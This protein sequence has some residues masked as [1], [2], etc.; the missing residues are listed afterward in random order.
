MDSNGLSTAPLDISM[1]LCRQ[2]SRSVQHVFLNH[3]LQISAYAHLHIDNTS[4]TTNMSQAYS[5]WKDSRVNY[6]YHNDTCKFRRHNV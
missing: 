1:T 4:D 3:M 5:G 2:V 6:G